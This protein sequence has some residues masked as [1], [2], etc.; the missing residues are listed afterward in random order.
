MNATKWIDSNRPAPRRDSG[1]HDGAGNDSASGHGGGLATDT[2]ISAASHGT[3]RGTCFAGDTKISG[4]GS[5]H[6]PS[7]T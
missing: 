6:S 2:T 1:F 4:I 7:F 5:G 3:G